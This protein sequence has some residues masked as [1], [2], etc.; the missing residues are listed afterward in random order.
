VKGQIFEVLCQINRGF[1]Q[2]INGLATLRR[3]PAFHARE[4]D[5]CADLAKE[6]RAVINSYL[7]GMIEA[8]E[9]AE[10]GRRY[11]KRRLQEKKEEQD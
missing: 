10:A 7:A 6:N 8:A 9:T 3:H 5:R 1:Q 11:R 4:L 2:A